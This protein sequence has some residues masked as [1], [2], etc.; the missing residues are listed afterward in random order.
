MKKL[1][2]FKDFKRKKRTEIKKVSSNPYLWNP[3]ANKNSPAPGIEVNIKPI[4]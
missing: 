2:K 3:I 1:K 4:C